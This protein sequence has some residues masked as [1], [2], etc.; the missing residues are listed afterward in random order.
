MEPFP[1]NHSTTDFRSTGAFDFVTRSFSAF[2]N[3]V[4]AVFLQTRTSSIAN[5]S[6]PA[7]TATSDTPPTHKKNIVDEFHKARRE[8]S[9]NKVLH[10][11]DDFIEWNRS[12]QW[13][14][15]WKMCRTQ[16]DMATTPEE[17]SLFDA[18]KDYMSA[19]FDRILVLVEGTSILR[20]MGEQT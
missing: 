16:K 19:V 2:G 7:P 14:S 12:T 13:L 4:M 9:V 10:K 15:A 8:P 3:A 6:L 18:Q 5:T 1:T 11:L 20:E 17:I